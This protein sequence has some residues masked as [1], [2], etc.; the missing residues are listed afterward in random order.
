MAEKCTLDGIGRKCGGLVQVY[1]SETFTNK[2]LTVCGNHYHWIQT[3]QSKGDG[4][5]A[6]EIFV[7]L[8]EARQKLDE[9]KRIF[10]D[11]EI[12]SK[13]Y[14]REEQSK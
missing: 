3:P 14:E 2:T 5:D 1:R 12:S 4:D 10:K 7:L 9:I 11:A 6:T 13:R 8:T